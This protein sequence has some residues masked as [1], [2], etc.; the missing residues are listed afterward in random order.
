[1]PQGLI[2]PVKGSD[3]RY[4]VIYELLLTNTLGSPADL[5][6]VE[7]LDAGSG[8]S[9]LKLAA[10]DIRKGEYLHA[11]D[12]KTA[13]STTFAPFSGQTLI[14]NL[15]FD[16]K[17][18]I[19]ERV[20]QRFE[21]SGTDPF[22]N[23]AATFSYRSPTVKIAT[24]AE[25]P[26]LSPPLEGEGWLASDGC[27]GP[28]GHVS[29]L[30]GLNGRLQASERFA[31]DWIKIDKEGHVFNGDKS[32]LESWAGFGAKVLSV[33]AGVV[34]VASDGMEEHAPGAMPEGLAF[35]QHP[36]NNV[37]IALDKGFTAVYAH[38][39][40][41]S[42]KVK[43]GDRV[44][45]GDVLGFLGNTGGSLAPH[46]HF[47]IVNGPSGFTSDGYPYVLDSF[48]VATHADPAV[49][50]KVFAGEAT[51]PARD[52]LKPE[53]RKDELPLNFDVVDFPNEP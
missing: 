3:G 46:L 44:K 8:K 30:I 53:Q 26:V 12:R 40:P 33:G 31:I 17:S 52:T 2:A 14:L 41:G 43:V 51:F 25:P 36:G 18:D 4:H 7:V 5:R 16:A 6:G 39:R 15:G 38:F 22:T 27:C 42:I 11:L 23:K 24:T 35:A 10:D 29:A 47:H 49:L 32:K 9:L 45:A 13:D 21:V 1:V 50:T 19:P 34:T 20:V 48:A 37:A 28:T